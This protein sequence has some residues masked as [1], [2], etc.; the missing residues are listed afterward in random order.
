M[1]EPGR[2]HVVD[3]RMKTRLGS[4]VDSQKRHRMAEEADGS[5]RKKLNILTITRKLWQ[6]YV[7]ENVDFL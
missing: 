4:L 7:Q 1:E 5:R 6:R 2:F 3:H